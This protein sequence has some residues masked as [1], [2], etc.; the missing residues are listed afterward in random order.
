MWNAGTKDTA[1]EDEKCRKRQAVGQQRLKKEKYCLLVFFGIC[2]VS[3]PF[4]SGG[5][6]HD[7]RAWNQGWVEIC[8]FSLAGKRGW[9]MLTKDGRAVKK[10]GE[11]TELLVSWLGA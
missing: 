5:K 4:W 6:R 11:K 7:E 1:R 9:V 3:S 2:P 8:L 10:L